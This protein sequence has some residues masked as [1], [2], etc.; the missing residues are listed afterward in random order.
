MDPDPGSPKTYGS[1]GSGLGS[2]TLIQ[3]SCEKES[4]CLG[5]R[6]VAADRQGCAKTLSGHFLL[7][8]GTVSLLQRNTDFSYFELRVVAGH[9]WGGTTEGFGSGS[10][11][12]SGSALI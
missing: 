2:A 1:D 3:S 10:V 12:G 4:Q 8:T 6:G 9:N 5:Q 7:F 11:S